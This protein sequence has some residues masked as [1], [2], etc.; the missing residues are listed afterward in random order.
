M[1]RTH[2]NSAMGERI[3]KK[4]DELGLNAKQL[5]LTAGLNETYVRDLLRAENPNPRYFHLRALATTLAVSTHWLATGD[6]EDNVIDFWDRRFDKKESGH[7][8]SFNPSLAKK[9]GDLSA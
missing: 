9:D 7:E 8:K 3:I 6:G 2:P 4:M 1:K 5:S